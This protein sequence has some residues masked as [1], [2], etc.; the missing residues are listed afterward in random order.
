AEFLGKSQVGVPIDEHAAAY[1]L[2]NEYGEKVDAN[3]LPAALSLS[4]GKAIKDVT[5]VIDRPD[6][7]I[8]VAMSA[9]PLH[10]EGRVSGVVVTFRDIT[11]RRRLQEDM[12]SQAERAQILADAGAFFSS[13]IDPAWVTQAIAERVAE[14]LGDWA[15]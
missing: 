15:A 9:T 14:V 1:G 2:R 8:T 12:Q 4:T 10:D 7:Q 11:D 6:K 3:E 5:M 13:T